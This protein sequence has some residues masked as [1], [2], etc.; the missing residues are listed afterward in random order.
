MGYLH[1]VGTGAC[2]GRPRRRMTVPLPPMP[3]LSDGETGLRAWRLDDIDCVAQAAEDARIPRG[4]TVPEAFTT[5]AGLAWIE[6]QWSRTSGGEGWSSAIVDARTD[7]AVGCL[8]LLLRRQEGV[9]G[10]GY[11][12]VP[13][14][15]GHGHARRA[16]ALAVSW[17]LGDGAFSRVE[18]WVEPGNHRSVA[19]LTVCGFELEGRLRSFLSFADGRSDAL[20]LSR[21]R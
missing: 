14:A 3:S 6:R 15:R 13:E 5:D 1:I 18:A 17:A 9:V 7:V 19:V 21:V 20:V 2:L 16:V 10:I 12:L 4:T 8:A 11:W